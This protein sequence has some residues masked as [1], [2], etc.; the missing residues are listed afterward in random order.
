VA[1]ERNARHP[2]EGERPAAGGD[3]SGRRQ[4]AQG[5]RGAGGERRHDRCAGEQRAARGGGEQRAIEQPAR[6]EA[7][8]H[9]ERIAAQAC[10]R[11]REPLVDLADAPGDRR[12]ETME[13]S[14]RANRHGERRAERLHRLGDQQQRRDQEQC[15]GEPA[16][17]RQRDDRAADAARERAERRVGGD[18]AEVIGQDDRRRDAAEAAHPLRAA[19]GTL[20]QH[21][22]AAHR[23]AMQRAADQADQ[24]QRADQPAMRAAQRVR[25]TDRQ[26]PLGQR[27]AVRQHRGFAPSVAAVA[28]LGR[29]AVRSLDL[30]Q[31]ER[32]R[33]RTG[34]AP[35]PSSI[36]RAMSALRI[37][38]SARQSLM[39][40]DWLTGC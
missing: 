35:F 29:F 7:E 30:P 12:A 8:Q 33:R 24:R 34:L 11:V 25:R 38:A 20:R 19:L 22:R 6:Q 21:E 9:A 1:R 18:A 16:E 23:R 14:R 28:L 39:R 27:R 10:R 37:E 31:R 17:A 40:S 5:R 13:P 15:R 4:H 3:V 26:K 32:S 36:R 2:L